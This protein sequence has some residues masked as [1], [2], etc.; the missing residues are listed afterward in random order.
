MKKYN[1]IFL[2][3]CGAAAL[4]SCD[5]FLDEL[6]DDRAELNSIEKVKS[7]LVSAYPTKLPD[8][9]LEYSSDNV[10]C[11][12]NA[13]NT[14]TDQEKLYRWEDVE[15]VNYN[16]T[17]KQVWNGHYTAIATANQALEALEELEAGAQ[18]DALKA[19][20]LL[21][22][23]YGMFNLAN[24]FCMAW[25]PDKAEEYPGL[26]YPKQAGI[27][28][29]ERGTLAQLYQNIND[30]IEQAL[31]LLNDSYLAVPKYHFNAKAA[32][33]FAARFNLYYLNNDKAIEYASRVLG[34]NPESV[35][36]NVSAYTNLAGVTDI[37]N[38]YMRDD[39]NLMMVAA[40][41]LIG[42]AFQG[43]G[44]FMRYA[45]NQEITSNETFWAKMPWGSG[46]SNNVLYE[47]RMLYGNANLVYYPKM[48]E[49]FEVTDKVLQT[50]FAHT[51]DP[52]FTA[53]ETLL[54]RAEAYARKKE[55]TKALDDMNTW[56]R[57]HC[58]TSLG[59]AA[60][61][62]LTEE[63]VNTFVNGLAE[64]P[65]V[66][67]AT[68]QRGPKKPLH[69]QGFKVE[70]GTMTNMLHLILHMRRLETYWQ[71]LRF[72]DIKRYGIEFSHNLDGADPIAFKAGDLRGA[73]QLP[74]DVIA[75]GLSAN[76][77]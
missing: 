50:G 3:L 19:E 22:R 15:D 51:V 60:R 13:Y 66:I 26:P 16:D 64:V 77:R 62:V 7:F 11:N 49:Q 5:K 55:Y 47:A 43:S 20:A 48:L 70:E 27:S 73:I 17:P 76:P 21:C 30:D 25:N 69:P 10:M 38:S 54:V 29:D 65:A 71:G 39:A 9:I 44:S 74:A 37:N 33:A 36:R 59:T 12:G 61:P 34:E 35:I 57:A 1:Y 31:P 4:S 6:P 41:S 72:L 23:A 67:T 42:R 32:Y 63:S 68:R 53:D 40:Y 56:V 75:A 2:T 18:G 46:S 45:H 52:V 8:Y 24:T 14:Y 58:H 28:V